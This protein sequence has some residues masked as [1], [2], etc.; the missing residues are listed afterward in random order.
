MF[1][2]VVLI[3]YLLSYLFFKIS[4][5]KI[6]TITIFLCKDVNKKICNGNRQRN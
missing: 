4:I 2:F 3:D 1:C 5:E 6:K